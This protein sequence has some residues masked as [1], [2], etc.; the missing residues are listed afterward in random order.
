MKFNEKLISLRKERGMSQEDLAFKVGVSRQSVS[1]WEQGE[2]EPDLTNL[3]SLSRVF[4]VTLDELINDAPDK[5]KPADTERRV[6][7][8]EARSF[9]N[10][11][12][13]SAPWIA[14]GVL[15]CILSPVCLI[16]LGA[17][18]EES[19]FSLSENVAA[20]IGII[21]LL[22]LIAL[23]VSVFVVQ[24][25]RTAEYRY[26]EKE[27]F[28]L[29]DEA[30]VLTNRRKE[31]YKSAYLR[32]NVLGVCLCLLSIAP[33]F[34]GVMIDESNDLLMVC[35]LSAL[36]PVAGVGVYFLVLGG[37][38]WGSLEK[39]LQ[40]E[41]YSKKNK[42]KAPL[43][44]A[45]SV[46]YWLVVTAIFLGVSFFTSKWQYTG[47]IWVIAGVLYPAFLLLLN[48]LQRPKDK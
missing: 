38:I 4:Q 30:A 2:S 20:G 28:V 16:L 34:I 41:D 17:I 32:N 11:T 26:L 5:E 22:V 37:V 33:L 43:S 35:L 9:L 45:L 6:S 31:E 3:K 1:K 19:R 27:S 39:L 44:S 21:A 24:G 13:K 7:L 40:I 12:R 29:D 47:L 23:A 15:L 18:S 42:N 48:A 14:L 10:A 36:F 25:G 8:E 46:A